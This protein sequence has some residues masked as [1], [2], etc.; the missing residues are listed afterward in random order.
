MISESLVCP[1]T[2][3]DR[4]L[5]NDVSADPSTVSRIRE[6]FARWLRRGH[7]MDESKLCDAVLAVNEALANAAEFAYVDG[8]AGTVD[9]EAVRD[10]GRGTLTVT[11]C[12]QGHWR[13]THSLRRERSRGRGI[14]LMRTLADSVIIDTS[15]LGTHVCLRFDDVLA[16][17]EPQVA[18]L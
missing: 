1:D 5:C 15:V 4:F 13:E 6:E 7:L 2:D 3:D 10:V 18:V 9:V 8:G 14:P 11:V 12:D 16:E 17:R